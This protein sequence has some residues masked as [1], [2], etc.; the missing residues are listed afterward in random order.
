[1]DSW[2][3]GR[4]PTRRLYIALVLAALLVVGVTACGRSAAG[5]SATLTLGGSSFTGA[6][7]VTIQAL[8]SV[9]FD[10]TSGGTH[11]LVTGISGRFIAMLDAPSQL[12]RA[13]GLRLTAGDKK[14]ITFMTPGTYQITC[15]LHPSMEALIIVT[16]ATG[17]GD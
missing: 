13:D 6:T 14:T 5:T 4:T 17:S 8:Q 7:S 2:N 11:D 15:A 1:M 16:T 3:A 10:D 12:S 9:T